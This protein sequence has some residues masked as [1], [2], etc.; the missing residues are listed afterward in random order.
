[1][2]RAAALY[3]QQNSFSAEFLLVFLGI[4]QALHISDDMHHASSLL[5]AVSHPICPEWRV[6]DVIKQNEPDYFNVLF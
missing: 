3:I 4:I 5:S 1:M 2:S 6:A